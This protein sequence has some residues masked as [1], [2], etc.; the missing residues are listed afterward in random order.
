[1]GVKKLRIEYYIPV[2]PCDNIKKVSV[3]DMQ[4]FE[5]QLLK[6]KNDIDIQLPSINE[7]NG[8]G[9]GIYNCVLNRDLSISPCDLLTHKY[10]TKEMTNIDEFINLWLH[11]DA[12]T[13]WRKKTKCLACKNRYKCLALEEENEE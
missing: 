8:C 11:D 5:N 9:A 3:E 10:R 7:N 13:T 6:C 2:N 12:F 1:M 4:K